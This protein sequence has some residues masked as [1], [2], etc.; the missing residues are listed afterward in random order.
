MTAPSTDV[1]LVRARQAAVAHFCDDAE[2]GRT[3]REHL[4]R[5]PDLERAL[6]RLALDRGGPRDLAVIR[7]GLAAGRAAARGAGRRAAGRCWPRRG[8]RWWG[9]R[10]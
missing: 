1:A 3:V 8:R 9:T 10:R 5:V 7:D 2:A 6:S 4:R